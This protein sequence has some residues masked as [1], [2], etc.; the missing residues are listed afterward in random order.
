MVQKVQDILLLQ[1]IDTGYILTYKQSQGEGVAT[2]AFHDAGLKDER[3][4]ML[5]EIINLLGLKYEYELVS[6][7][8]VNA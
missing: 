3:A 5:Q 8:K 6:R 2:K 1:A 7:N 4:R